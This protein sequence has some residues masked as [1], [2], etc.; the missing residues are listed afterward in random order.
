M[1]ISAQTLPKTE[2]EHIENYGAMFVRAIN[3]EATDLHSKTVE[4]VFSQAVIQTDGVAKI[5]T[6]FPKIR[7]AL[8]ELEYHHSDLT[9]FNLGDKTS[10]VLHVFAKSKTKKSWQDFQLRIEPNQPHKVVNLAFIAEVAEPIS[11][12][13]SAIT[14]SNTINWLNNYID[15]LITD[16]DLSEAF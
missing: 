11:L 4:E 8:G 12:P 1:A 14:D 16:N 15:K 7:A 13:N 10:Y 5:S 3:S 6:L 2:R 9:E